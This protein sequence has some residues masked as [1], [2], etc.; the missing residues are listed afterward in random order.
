MDSGNCFLTLL[1][2][3][4]SSY[5]R[6]AKTVVIIRAEMLQRFFIQLMLLTPATAFFIAAGETFFTFGTYFR[7][8]QD[9]IF[10]S[11]IV[12]VVTSDSLCDITGCW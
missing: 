9:T 5:T 3:F 12:G 11:A 10:N 1:F 4:K 2:F 8:H 7:A 6:V